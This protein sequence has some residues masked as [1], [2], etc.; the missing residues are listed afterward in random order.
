[1]NSKGFM[2]KVM[3]EIEKEIEALQQGKCWKHDTKMF[4]G[5]TKPFVGYPSEVVRNADKMFPNHGLYYHAGC[6]PPTLSE[7]GGQKVLICHVCNAKA[8]DYFDNIEYEE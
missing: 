6:M 8:Q 2:E 1:M 3:R 4:R 5:I 7:N